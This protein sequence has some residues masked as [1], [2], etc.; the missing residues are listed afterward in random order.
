MRAE[1]D[2]R[3][4]NRTVAV[5][6]VP[7]GYPARDA[8]YFVDV[9]QRTVRP[10]AGRSGTGGLRDIPGRGRNPRVRYGPMG[11]LA[12]R[13]GRMGMPAPRKLRNR[14]RGV[15][16]RAHVPCSVRRIMRELG[17][18]PKRP[19]TK[20]AAA[21]GDDAVRR[22]RACAA[23]AILRARRRKTA[24]VVQD[25]PAFVRMGTNGRRLWSRVGEGAAAGRPGRRDRA[26]ACGSLAADGTGPVRP[27]GRPGGD[28][29]L[30]YPREIHEAVT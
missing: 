2:A 29:F 12:G 16:G 9:E 17:F 4:R 14:V 10:W 15:P 7:G 20:Y 3:I 5:R 27:C 13:L 8:A 30:A 22:L 23:G 25:G 19:A 6:G 1:R 24:T 18:S 11:R 28:T 26:A 21:A